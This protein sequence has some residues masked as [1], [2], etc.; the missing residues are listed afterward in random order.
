MVRGGSPAAAHFLGLTFAKF[1]EPLIEGG[2]IT[3]SEFVDAVNALNDPSVSIVMP[4]TVAAW[5]R[6]R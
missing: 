2:A 6:R 5:G 4:M 3:K 1:E